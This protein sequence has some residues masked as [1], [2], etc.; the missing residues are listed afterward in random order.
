MNECSGVYNYDLGLPLQ[1]W[2][3]MMLRMFA[4]L[5]LKWVLVYSFISFW[6]ISPNLTN[7][8][9]EGDRERES[10]PL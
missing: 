8:E 3:W 2:W 5:T 10:E 6:E 1:Y 7:Y 4:W 9:R